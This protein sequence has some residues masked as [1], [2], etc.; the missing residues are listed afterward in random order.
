NS[1]DHSADPLALGLNTDV[2][3]PDLSG[4][5]NIT[6]NGFAAVG[7]TQPLG[8]IDKTIHFTD[9]LSYATGA[10]QIKIGGEARVTKLFIFYDSNKRGTFTFDGT[11]GPW[12]SLPASSASASLKALADYMAGSA[13]TASIVRGNT[14]HNYFQNSFDAFVQ[15]ALTV[16]PKITLNYGVRY[17]YPGVLGA[18][19]A[20]PTN[21]LPDR[22]MVTTD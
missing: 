10:H 17:T 22:G 14:H 20:P 9:S 18:S 5:P 13:A 16:S 4:P 15:D 7:G 21:S 11:V 8:R 2:T 1:F 12:A 19:D 6:I 3:D